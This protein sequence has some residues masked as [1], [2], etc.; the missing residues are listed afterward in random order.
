M[1]TIITKD[2]DVFLTFQYHVPFFTLP[3]TLCTFMFLSVTDKRGWLYRVEDMSY[4][5]KQTLLWRRNTKVLQADTKVR[6]I[7][8]IH[9]K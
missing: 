6:K 4:P 2:S 8:C 1:P 7:K 9:S 5:E 3:F